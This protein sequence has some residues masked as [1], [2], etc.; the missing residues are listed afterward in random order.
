M[1]LLH[2]PRSLNLMKIITDT[3]NKTT[4]KKVF[5]FLLFRCFGVLKACGAFAPQMA[6]KEN[7]QGSFLGPS[8]DKNK[9][10]VQ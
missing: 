8:E 10:L 5:L 3:K 2:Q 7:P 4:K 6:K 9:D 1:R